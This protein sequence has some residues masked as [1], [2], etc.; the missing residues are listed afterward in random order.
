MPEKS[1]GIH[2]GSWIGDSVEE[3]KK[4]PTWGKFAAVGVLAVVVFLAIRARS[5]SSTAQKAAASTASTDPLGTAGAAT[6]GTQS[7]FPMV[8]N[9]PVI[10]N[11]VNPIFDSAGNPI[12]YQQ[13]PAPTVP[14]GAPP[15]TPKPINTPAPAPAPIKLLPGGSPNGPPVQKPVAPVTHTFMANPTVYSQSATP[16]ITSAAPQYPHRPGG[17]YGITPPPPPP[18]SA[19]PIIGPY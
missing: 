5:A 12:A 10:P 1:G 19:K 9:L 18:R 14:G 8:G 7:P 11:N 17:N 16:H 2:P 6:T 4:L 3:F 15:P 13:G